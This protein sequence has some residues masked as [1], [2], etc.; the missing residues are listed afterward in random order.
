M[1]INSDYRKQSRADL[2]GKWAIAVLMTLVYFIISSVCPS[3]WL[4]V[5]AIFVT[6][7]L[8]YSFTIAILRNA[9]RKALDFADMFLGFKD[10]GRFLGT[11]LLVILYSLLWSLLLIIPG[12]I[13][14]YAYAMTP[15][16]LEDNP[17]L[18]YNAAIEQS[19][20]MM[21]GK[22]MQLFLLDLSF[23]GW[24]LLSILTLGIGLLWVQPY[25]LGARAA[26]YEDL[27]AEYAAN[28]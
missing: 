27:K 17:E 5:L 10:Y 26:F 12:V 13:K 15:Y 20:R 18:K 14:I 6:P 16:L 1:K 3:P 11:S 24:C 25:M 4:S 8:A 28:A 23:I 2:R 21:D 9:R 7:V 19:M 22:K